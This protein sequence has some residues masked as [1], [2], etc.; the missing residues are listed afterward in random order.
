MLSRIH[1]DC[2]N[3]KLRYLFSKRLQ[4]K[5]RAITN[6][7]RFCSS[8]GRVMS[9]ITKV[10]QKEIIILNDLKHIL[11]R[12]VTCMAKKTKQHKTELT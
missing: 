2:S 3:K 6:W 5:T 1:N 7:L 11:L 10:L 8:P 9:L 4:I 12:L